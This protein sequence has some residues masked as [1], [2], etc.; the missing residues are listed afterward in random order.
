VVLAWMYSGGRISVTRMQKIFLFGL[1]YSSCIAVPLEFVLPRAAARLRGVRRWTRNG[2]YGLILTGFAFAGTLVG[3]AVLCTAGFMP[4]SAYWPMVRDASQMSLLL[5]YGFGV[6]GLVS[7]HMQHHVEELNDQLRRKE[8]VATEARLASL[9]ARVHPHF[10]FNAINS[11]LSLMRD[12]PRRAEHLLERMAALMRVS[13]EQSHGRMVPLRQELRIVEDYLEI[14]H[15]RFAERL[16][17]S[18]EAE[19]GLDAEVPPLAVQTLV[20]NSVKYAV[21]P[22][23]EGGTIRVAARARGGEAEIEVWDDGPGFE[24]ALAA[25]GNGLGLVRSRVEGFGRLEFARGANGGMAVRLILPV[26]VRA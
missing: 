20:E 2:A 25:G 11:I 24:A 15:A 8:Q 12:D 16:R 21:S 14:E 9:E 3:S 13:L 7:G 19:P 18:V 5:T 23:R 10:L 1:V 26:A 4:W 22:R 17:Y 6:A